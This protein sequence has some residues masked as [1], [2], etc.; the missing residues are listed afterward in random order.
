M[1]CVNTNTLINSMRIERDPRKKEA[2]HRQIYRKRETYNSSSSSSRKSIHLAWKHHRVECSFLGYGSL[3]RF[4]AVVSYTHWE[5]E[6][7]SEYEYIFAT[8]EEKHAK[9]KHKPNICM[10]VC[11][12]AKNERNWLRF[13]NVIFTQHFPAFFRSSALLRCFVFYVRMAPIYSLYITWFHNVGWLSFIL[14]LIL[15][16]SH[17]H[18]PSRS[19]PLLLLFRS[20]S[21]AGPV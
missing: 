14:M 18:T 5:R 19:C 9:A 15:F 13:V 1:E 7:V 12:C 8:N 3:N 6:R 16:S 17:T 10:C 20:I 2:P 11:E 4:L 21:W